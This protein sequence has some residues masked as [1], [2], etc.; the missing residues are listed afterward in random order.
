MVA[1]PEG[2]PTGGKASTSTANVPN[3]TV[4]GYPMLPSGARF[5][6]TII[7]LT[8]TEFLVVQDGGGSGF[9]KELAQ[10]VAPAGVAVDQTALSS[11][12]QAENAAYT[13]K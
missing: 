13:G 2:S 6:T 11:V 1:Y 10:T 3:T 4:G 12:L 5:D 9:T 7:P 8:T